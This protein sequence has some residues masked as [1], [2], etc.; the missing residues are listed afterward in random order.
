MSKTI[1]LTGP[2]V[3]RM[4]GITNMTLWNWRQG[5]KSV[6]PLPTLK[7]KKV[8]ERPRVF[9]GASA[10]LAW[11]KRNNIAVVESVEQVLK[12]PATGRPGPKPKQPT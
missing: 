2:Q 12:Q 4:F 8:S 9:Y 6:T 7:P 10:T 1:Q 11:A 5:T 3:C